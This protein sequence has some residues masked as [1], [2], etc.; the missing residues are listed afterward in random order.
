MAVNQFDRVAG[1]YDSLARL[2]F[3][4]T[5]LA[6][7]VEFQNEIKASDRVLILG[8]GTG[9]LLEHLLECESIDF[10]EKS[11]KMIAKANDC[12]SIQPINFIEC[13]FLAFE[14]NQAYDVIICP[15]FLDCFD[16]K[17]LEIVLAKIKSFLAPNG[18]L[19]VADFDIHKTN[20]WLSKAMHLFF[21]FT[22]LLG[23]E[24]LLPIRDVITSN[25]FRE[26][27]IITHKKGIFSAIYELGR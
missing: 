1:I 25:G 8:G 24:K 23:T 22:V 20:R 13:D 11:S 15:F 2:V 17:L 5:I 18:K 9:K 14:S 21:R 4:S 6:S 19:M 3:G 7:Q 12:K 16:L 10:V 27:S 26:D